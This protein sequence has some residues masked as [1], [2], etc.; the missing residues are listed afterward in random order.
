MDPIYHPLIERGEVTVREYLPET[1]AKLNLNETDTM[2]RAFVGSNAALQFERIYRI[3]FGSQI[4]LLEQ[5]RDV[6]G[7]GSMELVNSIY[8][9][10]ANTYPEPYSRYTREQW[11]DFLVTNEL[12]EKVDDAVSLTEPGQEFLP[13]ITTRG[14]SN[15]PAF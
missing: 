14:Y 15:R 1:A 9:A 5:L 11:L 12:I 8:D 6:G 13:Y 7:A 10:A 4:V 3:I 2:I